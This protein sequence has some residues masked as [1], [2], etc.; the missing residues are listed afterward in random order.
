MK[1]KNEIIIYENYAEIILLNRNKQESGRAIIDLED[2]EKCK[3]HRWYISK[4]KSGIQYASSSFHK[5]HL[6]LHSF[7]KENNDKN[8]EIDHINGNGLDNR[9][10]NLRIVTHKENMNNKKKYKIYKSSYSQILGIHYN[11]KRNIWKIDIRING[12]RIKKS[13]FETLKEA[14]E[15]LEFIK[16]QI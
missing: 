6:I 12:K 14:S 4:M 7:L 9:K 11:K 3:I 5:K 1:I 8:F 16:S 13:P 2:I 10:N 15:Y